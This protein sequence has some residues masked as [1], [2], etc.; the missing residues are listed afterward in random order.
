M[1][2]KTQLK[3]HFD[4]L[5]SNSPIHWR[6][7]IV[8]PVKLI[9]AVRRMRIKW[10][11]YIIIVTQFKCNSFT[12]RWKSSMDDSKQIF[13]DFRINLFAPVRL[14]YRIKVAHELFKLPH[15]V[16]RSRNMLQ[17][18][19]EVEKHCAVCEVHGS[20]E[21]FEVEGVGAELIS[22]IRLWMS[23]GFPRKYYYQKS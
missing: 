2:D 14:A 11:K 6:N 12:R 9:I 16:S 17:F 5:T 10:T 13:L 15:I 23:R 1:R 4:T 8:K 18:G 21:V 22:N 7:M 19:H 3:S 20:V